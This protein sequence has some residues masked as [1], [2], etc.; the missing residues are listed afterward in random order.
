MIHK[1]VEPPKLLPEFLIMSSLSPRLESISDWYVN[2]G[3]SIFNK[4]SMMVQFSR[5][6][7]SQAH[8]LR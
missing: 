2:L 6:E 5:L 7:P 3:R 4:L 1:L 8:D